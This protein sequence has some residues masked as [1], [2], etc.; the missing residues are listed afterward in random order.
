MHI[1]ARYTATTNHVF[2]QKSRFIKYEKLENPIEVRTGDLNCFI[3]GTGSI[4][5]A[6]NTDKGRRFL[7]IDNVQ[8]IPGFHINIIAYEAFKSGGLRPHDTSCATLNSKQVVN[9]ATVERWHLRLGHMSHENIAH[10][11]KNMYGVKVTDSKKRDDTNE[12]SIL[13]VVCNT[14]VSHTKISRQL[15]YKGEAPFQWTQIDLI[16][17]EIGL[18]NEQAGLQSEF[19]EYCAKHAIWQEKTSTDTKEPNGAAERFGGWIITVDRKLI[20][21]SGF[22][23][24]LWP[25]FLLAAATILNRT[26]KKAPGYKTPFE[27]VSKRRPDL[28]GYYS[29]NNIP[30]LQKQATRSDIGYYISNS[31]GNISIIWMPYGNTVI[32]SRDVRIDET[33]HSRWG[34][35][36]NPTNTPVFED[37]FVDVEHENSMNQLLEDVIEESPTSQNQVNDISRGTTNRLP[38][39][40]EKLQTDFG[41]NL[42][43]PRATPEV[44]N[45]QTISR[46]TSHGRIEK[47]VENMSTPSPERNAEPTSNPDKRPYNR[48]LTEEQV[49]DRLRET[50]RESRARRRNERKINLNFYT[51]VSDI[52]NYVFIICYQSEYNSSTRDFIYQ[53]LS[54]I[55]QFTKTDNLL[56]YDGVATPE[57]RTAYQQRIGNLIYPADVLR[58][59]ISFAAAM[60]SR[61]NQNPTPDHI[62]ETGYV[63]SYLAATKHVGIRYSGN[64]QPEDLM[65]AASDAIFPDDSTRKLTQGFLIKLFGGPIAWQSTLQRTIFF[66]YH[67]SRNYGS[68]LCWSRNHEYK[69]TIQIDPF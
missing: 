57:Q 23:S 44:L 60:L 46:E 45:E 49:L 43:T 26:P 50:S 41:E 42:P 36:R 4:R 54:I 7:R 56:P 35:V 3:I 2:H 9:A 68:N 63:I 37:R 47:S 40:T 48:K 28:S 53:Q 11:S 51:E 1:T 59:D 27:F 33:S 10:L 38:E 22:P 16:H 12:E 32:S 69:T 65:V 8:H 29:W 24:N 17:E 31:A 5:L 58:P 66:I 14:A 67:R 62:R 64:L 61:F 52:D 20:L 18:S 30:A 25:Y 39:S 19:I 21:Q 15:Q 6:V 13:F 55:H 34:N